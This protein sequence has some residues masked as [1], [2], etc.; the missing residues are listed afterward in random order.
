MG[1]S[2]FTDISTATHGPAARVEPL[3]PISKGEGGSPD[4]RSRPGNGRA[5]RSEREP[6]A[7]GLSW[8]IF[9]ETFYPGTKRHHLPA[10]SAWSRYRD[11]DRSWPKGA[12]RQSGGLISER[13]ARSER[14]AVRPVLAVVDTGTVS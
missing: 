6:V 9:S 10:I 14:P 7:D 12:Q 1:T 13:H 8:E 4:S 2:E 11:G 5:T 3:R